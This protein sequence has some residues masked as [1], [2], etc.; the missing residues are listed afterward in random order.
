MID[1]DLSDLKF[2]AFDFDG[3]FTDNSVYV[4][5]NGVESVRCS[6]FDGIG[7]EK[8]KKLNIELAILSSE[9]NPLVLKRAK[10]LNINCQN[11]IKDKAA[12]LEKNI[13]RLKITKKNVMFVGNDINDIPAFKIAQHSVAV[14]DCHPDIDKYIDFKLSKSGGHGAVR[15]LCDLIYLN[16]LQ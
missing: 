6:R 5:E 3:V 12:E 1:K 9:T 13:S 14:A 2:I 10:K 4:D 7:L 11:S 15:E 8:L 16:L